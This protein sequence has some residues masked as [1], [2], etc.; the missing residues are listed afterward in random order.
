LAKE[1]TTL[2]RPI[3]EGLMSRLLVVIVLL[4]AGV[5]GLGFYQGWFRLSRDEETNVTITVDKEKIQE[6]KEKVQGLGHKGKEK[7]AAP[8]DK[9]KDVGSGP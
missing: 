9:A 2:F 7:T 6:D 3:E 8:T 1:Q 5:V 4:V